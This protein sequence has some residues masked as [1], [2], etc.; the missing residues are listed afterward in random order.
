MIIKR[1]IVSLFALLPF[2]SSVAQ[3][4][5]FYTVAGGYFKYKNHSEMFPKVRTFQTG[6]TTADSVYIYRNET[7]YGVSLDAGF[8]FKRKGKGPV[9]AIEAGVGYGQSKTHFKD[10]N[11]WIKTATFSR[12]IDVYDQRTT[13]FDAHFSYVPRIDLGKG[14]IMEPTFTYTLGKSTPSEYPESTK[15]WTDKEETSFW[16]I[17]FVPFMF[18]YRFEQKPHL[19]VRMA[20]GG[21]E[22]LRCTT[23]DKE[24]D[25]IYEINLNQLFAAIVYYF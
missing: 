2:V 13:T 21:L 14:F 6:V 20:L 10:E 24:P 25:V 23:G 12:R 17:S 8:M 5:G 19:G 11:L 18:E 3:D 9:N 7:G 1:L 22:Y 16:G 15:E 4:S